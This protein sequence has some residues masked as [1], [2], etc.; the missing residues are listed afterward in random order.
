[1]QTFTLCCIDPE[2]VGLAALL[3]PLGV[4][5]E[6]E[7]R[8]LPEGHVHVRV[9]GKTIVCSR[10]VRGYGGA[11]YLT[12]TWDVKWSLRNPEGFRCSVREEMTP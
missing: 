10:L 7:P 1:M 3:A 9:L 12:A 2:G 5:Y 8:E 6:G 11:R 4:V